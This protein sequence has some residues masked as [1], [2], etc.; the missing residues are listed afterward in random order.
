MSDDPE[1]LLAHLDAG[2]WRSLSRQKALL[3]LFAALE[4]ACGEQKAGAK[5]GHGHDRERLKRR[6]LFYVELLDRD[7]HNEEF[8][9]RAE[10]AIDY[11]R[12]GKQ[13]FGLDILAPYLVLKPEDPL[14]SPA[15]E[16]AAW[17]WMRSHK[18]KKAE[19]L[20][21]RCDRRPKVL[22]LRAYCQLA[23]GRYEQALE[24]SA[25]MNKLFPSSPFAEDVRQTLGRV[26]KWQ[27]ARR[28]K[29]K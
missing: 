12:R 9:R 16:V 3:L 17:L 4:R 20:L 19:A 26:Q 27:S 11:G 22:Q 2:A 5:R 25:A 1:A 18:H 21:S 8:A 6:L 29:R 7:D 13:A 14:F 23:K 24:T 28:G 10:K 15:S